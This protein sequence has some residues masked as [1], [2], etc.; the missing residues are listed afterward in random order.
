MLLHQMQENSHERLTD[1]SRSSDPNHSAQSSRTKLSE[2]GTNDGS[3]QFGGSQQSNLSTAAIIDGSL[4][5]T[6]PPQKKTQPKIYISH[7]SSLST[8]IDVP[9]L[10][11]IDEPF[12][13][14]NHPLQKTDYTEPK[15][16]TPVI[17]TTSMPDKITAI[18]TLDTKESQKALTNVIVVPNIVVE[19]EK[20]IQ[21]ESEIV[22]SFEKEKKKEVKLKSIPEQEVPTVN[23]LPQRLNTELELRLSNVLS[24]PIL[25]D[26]DNIEKEDNSL[27]STA[28]AS[29]TK[30][31]S[32][33]TTSSVDNLLV[34]A[35]NSPARLSV[36][37]S[38][39]LKTP[40]SVKRVSF[41]PD[42][43]QVL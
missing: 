42:N 23:I 19:R 3:F 17:T 26:F 16:R 24:I 18:K 22:I 27:D 11:P 6:A 37:H 8:P 25:P 39:Q 12:Q 2:I 13:N 40:K 41:V 1:H 34:V 15:G 21:K 35:Q 30:L 4:P 31:I 28:A 38:D 20:E 9:I 32:E 29:V 36:D 5:I 43:D 33:S 10:H 7:A 14:F